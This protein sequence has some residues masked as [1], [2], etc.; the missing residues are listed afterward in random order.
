ME[1]PHF[2]TPDQVA[3]AHRLVTERNP[4][5]GY[6]QSFTKVPAL[7]A[8]LR[9]AL[10]RS[11]EPYEICDDKLT[12]SWHPP[13]KHVGPHQD[14]PLSG[15]T[16][17]LAVCLQAPA[18]GGAT[19]FYAF[20]NGPETRRVEHEAGK[21]MI[22]DIKQWHSGEKHSGTKVLVGAKLRRTDA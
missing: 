9:A 15:S 6:L 14:T 4:N 13:G 10:E 3:A 16:H 5:R 7:H 8:M 20:L 11:G 18:E 21:A 19:R 17:K 12:L 1:L 22:F 2:L